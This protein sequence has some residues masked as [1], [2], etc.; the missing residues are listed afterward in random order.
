MTD[1]RK[2][3]AAKALYEKLHNVDDKSSPEADQIRDDLDPIWYALTPE[4]QDILGRYSAELKQKKAASRMSLTNEQKAQLTDILN[5][6]PSGPYTAHNNGTVINSD[7]KEIAFR[8][9]Y[10]SPK[11]FLDLIEFCKSLL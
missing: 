7:S 2:L 6:I 3:Q 9:V 8:V 10:T 4:E 5:K 1:S 11:P